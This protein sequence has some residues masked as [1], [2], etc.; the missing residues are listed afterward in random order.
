MLPTTAKEDAAS[1]AKKFGNEF[2]D[3]LDQTAHDAGQKIRHLYDSASDEIHHARNVVTTE[4]R[5]NPIRSSA[6]ALGAGLLLG[7]LIRR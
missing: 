1:S 7:M 5:T 3:G 2:K 6:V 4:I